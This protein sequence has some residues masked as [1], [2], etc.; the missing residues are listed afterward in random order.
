MLYRVRV[1][2]RKQV[3][4]C[5]T[6]SYERMDPMYNELMG[7]YISGKPNHIVMDKWD[8]KHWKYLHVADVNV[9]KYRQD[10]LTVSEPA[11]E[12]VA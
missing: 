5:V 2:R 12:A 1:F 8:G 6:G 11:A 10:S 3:L 9:Y 4:L 7:A